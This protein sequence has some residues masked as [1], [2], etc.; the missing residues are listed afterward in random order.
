[1]PSAASKAAD[2]HPIASRERRPCRN[3]SP[4]SMRLTPQW[5]HSKDGRALSASWPWRNWLAGSSWNPLG[6]VSRVRCVLRRCGM[7]YGPHGVSSCLSFGAARRERTPF[8]AGSEKG[9]TSLDDLVILE[10]VDTQGNVVPFGQPA[11][12]VLLTN[13]Y[14]RDQPLIRYDIADAMTITDTPCPCGSAHRRITDVRARMDGAFEFRGGVTVLAESSNRPC[15]PGLVWL[16]SSSARWITVSMWHSWSTAHATVR[17]CAENSSIC[18]NR[19]GLAAPEG[20]GAR[21]RSA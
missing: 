4:A 8:P 15:S 18:W 7:R 9:C 16:T 2:R 1:M 6:S 11:D 17:D 19:R 20:S 21:G 14:N 13:L 5:K 12:R 10:P 3:L